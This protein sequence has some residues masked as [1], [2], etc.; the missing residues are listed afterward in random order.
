MVYVVFHLHEGIGSEKAQVPR[1]YTI[2]F[3]DLEASTREKLS[4]GGHL[5]PTSCEKYAVEVQSGS[6]TRTVVFAYP[7][8]TMS[9]VVD[10]NPASP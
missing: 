10:L 8:L 6:Q 7:S 4:K 9:E 3:L 1:P 2:I 5:A